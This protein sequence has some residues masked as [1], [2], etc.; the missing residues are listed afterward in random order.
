MDY[1]MPSTAISLLQQMAYIDDIIK[2]LL[3]LVMFRQALI[4]C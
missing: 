1:I 4:G 3:T 2:F